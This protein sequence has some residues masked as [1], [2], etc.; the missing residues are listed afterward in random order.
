[1]RYRGHKGWTSSKLFTQIISSGSSYL[2][3]TTGGTPKKLGWNRGGVAVLSRK[4]AISLKR[5]KIGP[6]LLSM[7]NRT[8]HVCYR[9]ISKSMTLDDLE[10]P[11]RTMFQNTCVF[12]AQHEN[13][14]EDRPIMYV[15]S[16]NIRFVRILEGF[17]GEWASNDSGVIKNVDF[18]GFRTLRL[19]HLRK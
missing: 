9:L 18:Q 3:A 8:L 5:G 17:P 14:N 15:A 4:P 10:R 19:R 12:G 13:F 2:G 16:G 11:F 1:M 7:T 6:R